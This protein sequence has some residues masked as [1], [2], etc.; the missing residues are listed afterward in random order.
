MKYKYILGTVAWGASRSIDHRLLENREREFAATAVSCEQVMN[1]MHQPV[2]RQQSL[3]SF[4][5]L[6]MQLVYLAQV[7]MKI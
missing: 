7:D 1:A 4:D 3:A 6:P 5:K 2:A